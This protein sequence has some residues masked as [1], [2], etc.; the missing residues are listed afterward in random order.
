[1]ALVYMPDGSEFQS[2]HL[3]HLLI[4]VAQK[5]YGLE[6]DPVNNPENKN[7]VRFMYDS[8]TGDLVLTYR[9]KV[10]SGFIQQ[11]SIAFWFSP[12]LTRMS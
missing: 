7:L 1:M 6:H 4:E 5:V 12:Y 8:T 11:S 10:T 3:E 9:I 2:R